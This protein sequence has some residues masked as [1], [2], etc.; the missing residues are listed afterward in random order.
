MKT[1]ATNMK[2]YFELPF[3]ILKFPKWLLPSMYITTKSKF[4]PNYNKLFNGYIF[5]NLGC[6]FICRNSKSPTYIFA[7]VIYT[8]IANFTPRQKL[9]HDIINIITIM[10]RRLVTK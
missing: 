6:Q 1:A 10:L 9:D 4:P 3:N 5:N 2:I 8:L 7:K